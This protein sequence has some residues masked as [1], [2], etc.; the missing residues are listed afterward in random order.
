MPYITY[1]GYINLMLQKLLKLK[2]IHSRMEIN[3][4]NVPPIFAHDVALSTITKA[5]KGANGKTKKESFTELIFIDAVRKAALVRIIL[6]TSVL[7]DL[8]K[9]IEDSLKKVK[10]ELKSKDVPKQEKKE[11]KSSGSYL[12]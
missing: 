7:E 6:P 10:K 4:G 9:T 8:P 3:L 12:G 5:K 11:T 2:D 1:L